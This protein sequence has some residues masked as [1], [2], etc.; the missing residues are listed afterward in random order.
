MQNA[1][2][3]HR[4][5]RRRRGTSSGIEHVLG[6]PPDIAINHDPAALAMHAAN[7][8]RTLHVP[9]NV[10]KVSLK[11]LVG[12]QPIG[13]LWMS[14]DCR[15]H[16]KAKGGAPV[17]PS[18]RDLAWVALRWLRELP[19]WQRPRRI[20]LENVE[21][22]RKWCPLIDDG[23]CGLKPDPAR[24]RRRSR[25]GLSRP[26]QHTDIVGRAAHELLSTVVGKGSTQGVVAAH[27]LSLK[28]TERRAGDFRLFCLPARIF[29]AGLRGGASWIGTRSGVRVCELP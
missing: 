27:M 14:P 20:F 15:H 23:Q 9:H 12:N 2:A 21:E 22:F 5:L 10:W 25:R 8:P 24:E 29:P 13:L 28:G 26:T 6:R 19:P 4:Q 7:H 16:S 3:D 18:V 17:S 11:E 1:R